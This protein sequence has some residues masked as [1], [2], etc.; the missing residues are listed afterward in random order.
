[1]NRTRWNTTLVAAEMM[2]E[3]CIL[4]D[5]YKR[6]DIRIRYEYKGNEYTVRWNDWLNKKRPSR[7]HLKGGNRNTKPHEKWSY[8]KVNELFMKDDCELVSEYK[9][10]KQK[11]C[12]RYKGS[13]YYT[14]LDHWIHNHSRPHIHYNENEQCFREFLEEYDIEFETQK[15]FDDL[16][17]DKNY[18][19][20]FD[21]Y[22]PEFELL[23]EIDDRSHL[24]NDK[25]IMRGKLKDQYCIDNKLKLLRID[26][27]TDKN[28]DYLDALRQI[29]NSDVY[30]LRYGRLYQ[31]YHGSKDI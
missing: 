3:D 6:G 11:L 1:M 15:T 5:Q 26:T 8:E 27:T 4:L 23:V 14:T 18:A 17:T 2:K 21:F 12:Y 20:R 31:N 24:S 16:K 28:D 19:M 13:L 10:T 25:Q 30:V 7:P 22:I 9:N 29:D